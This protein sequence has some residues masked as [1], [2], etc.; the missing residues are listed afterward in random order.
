MRKRI[1]IS[2]PITGTEDYLFRFKKAELNL[3]TSLNFTS[4]V[5]PAE[6]CSNLPTD[7]EHEEYM[8]VCLNMLSMCDC[9]YM[10]HGWEKSEGAKEELGLAKAKGLEVIYE[11]IPE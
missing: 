11:D 9:I 10:L 2:G 8:S 6:I 3:I 4:I 7:F 1:Y 5:N